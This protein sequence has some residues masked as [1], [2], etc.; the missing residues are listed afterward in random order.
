MLMS[1]G[2]R[3]LKQM[4]VMAVR[5]C[6]K[7]YCGE[8]RKIMNFSNVNLSKIPDIDRFIPAIK[9]TLSGES[10]TEGRGPLTEDQLTLR[11][12]NRE[13]GMLSGPLECPHVMTIAENSAQ[14]A[15]AAVRNHVKEHM[16]GHTGRVWAVLGLNNT[17]TIVNNMR[18]RDEALGNVKREWLTE[19]MNA[20]EAQGIFVNNGDGNN[21]GGVDITG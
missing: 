21:S 7:L 9:R 17:V 16:P 18:E 8:D 1:G 11:K 15:F 20:F 10:A 12:L 2:K 4:L 5:N 6:F 19:L 13:V 14:K 3:L